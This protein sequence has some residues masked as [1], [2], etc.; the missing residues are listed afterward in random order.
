M[1]RLRLLWTTALAIPLAFSMTGC[2]RSANDAA[3]AAGH[4]PGNK[5]LPYVNHQ[6]VKEDDRR[7]LEVGMVVG[8]GGLEDNNINRLAYVAMQHIQPEYGVMGTVL[9]ANAPADF[10]PDLNELARRRN[11][12]VITVGSRLHS[13]VEQVAKAYPKVQFLALDDRITDRP[14]VACAEFA[15]NEPAYIAGALAGWMEETRGVLHMNPLH[16]V[17]VVANPSTASARRSVQGFV[18]GLHMADP[19]AKAVIR[20]TPVE[21]V[22]GGTAIARSVLANGADIVYAVGQNTRGVLT[23]AVKA[24]AYVIGSGED[25]NRFA[26]SHVLASTLLKLESPTREVVYQVINGDFHGGPTTWNLHNQGVGFTALSPAV[27]KAV[28]TRV[29]RLEQ[30]VAANGMK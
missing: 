14:N 28:S 16:V 6:K 8:P 21:P 3:A 17:G 26:P 24:N 25:M 29:R 9:E 20:Y 27:P 19:F 7:P 4:M 22:D 18:S 5:P 13:A 23:A 15:S 2:T 10:L 30:T 1:H 11:A 12:L